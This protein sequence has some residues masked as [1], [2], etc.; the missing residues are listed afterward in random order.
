M[1]PLT[2]RARTL[3]T[4]VFAG[5]NLFLV[6]VCRAFS[7]PE[8]CGAS[9]LLSLRLEGHF[10]AKGGEKKGTSSCWK[11]RGDLPAR[12]RF[13]IDNRW[14]LKREKEGKMDDARKRR[15]EQLG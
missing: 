11:R 5:F 12:R 7:K 15:S 6:N 1:R 13:N 14:R 9:G 4:G 3:K 10:D 8:F 2:T